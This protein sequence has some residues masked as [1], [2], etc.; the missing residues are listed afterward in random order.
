MIEL[1]E[2]AVRNKQAI[3][4]Y[5]DPGWRM[6]EPHALGFSRQGN[7]LLRCFQISGASHSGEHLGW[8]LFRVD[9][10][11]N[12]PMPMG[13]FVTPRPGY[14]KGDSAMTGGILAEL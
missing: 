6:V 14:K 2:Q 4:V 1:L 11:A 7:L 9:S 10:V 13:N 3:K 8:K 12:V 5:Y